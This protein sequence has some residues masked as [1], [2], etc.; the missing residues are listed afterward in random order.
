M[1]EK[2][3]KARQLKPDDVMDMRFVAELEKE[4]FFKK[5]GQK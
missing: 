5:L 1:R 2:E 4:G 3:P